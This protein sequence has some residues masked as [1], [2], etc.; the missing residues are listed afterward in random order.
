MHDVEHA[1]VERHQCDQQQIRERD[2]GEFDG[3][4]PLRRIVGK[5][6]RQKCHRL[7]HERQR[8]DEQNDLRREQQREDAIAEKFRRFLAVLALDM[9][10]GRH[11]GR[12]ECA[13]RED[14]AEMVG[15]PQRHEKGVGHGPGAED[16]RKHDV[17]RE[18]CDPRQ[19]GIAADGENSPEH[20]L[21]LQHETAV[22]NAQIVMKARRAQP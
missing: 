20:P 6:R 16:R 21:L 7:R 10:I 19:K 2:A 3:E 12:I 11:E 8:K 22:Q 1:A 14:R 18:P 13:L 15:K 9:G 5:S 4:L 17:A